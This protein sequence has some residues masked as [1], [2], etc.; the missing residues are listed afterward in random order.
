MRK[1]VAIIGGGLGGLSAAITLANHDFDVTLFE[2]NTHFGG[3]MMPVKLGSAH[4]DFGPNTITMPHIFNQV[5]EQTGELAESY[6][7]FQKL[8]R[9][10]LNQFADGSSFYFSSDT[11]FLQDQLA[12]IDQQDAKRLPAYLEEVSKIY[13]IAEK[14]FFSKRFTS[15]KEYLSPSLM[16]AMSQVRPFESMHHFHRRFFQHPFTLQAFDRYATYIGSSPYQAPATFSLI[17]HLELNQGVYYHKGGNV[18]IA[19]AY[20]KLAKKLGV[21]L[22]NEMEV[23]NIEVKDAQ[24]TKLSTLNGESFK[25]D[26]VVVNGDLLSQYPVLIDEKHRPHMMDDK[27][28]A[29]PPSIS[30]FVVMAALNQKT[31]QFHHHNIYFSKDYKQE[32]KQLF[33]GQMPEDPTIY[34]CHSA[35]TEPLISPEGDNLLILVNAP[36]LQKEE[37]WSTKRSEAYKEKLYS[38]LENKGLK[39]KKYVKQENLMTPQH[40]ANSFYAHKGALYGISAHR[41]IDAFFRPSIKSRDIKNLFF[42]GG[43]VH[44]GGGSPMVVMSGQLAAQEIISKSNQ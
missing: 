33:S 42:T 44:P 40:I 29:Y 7:Q 35:Y 15:W 8:N 34:V 26:Y 20:V 41:K 21:M 5:I 22:L 12:Q 11:K 39:I 24:A 4:F 13:H 32:F 3:K 36:A 17:G 30:A 18:G 27:L 10:T 38:A 1:K 23:V 37:Q 14:H 6:L 2:K 28:K 19:D 25:F 31:D 16:L 43:T 9:H